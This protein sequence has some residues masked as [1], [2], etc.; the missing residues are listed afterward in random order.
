MLKR[1]KVCK[2]HRVGGGGGEGG[3]SFQAAADGAARAV[4]RVSVRGAHLPL[5]NTL[6]ETAECSWVRTVA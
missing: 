4:L 2:N 5:S 3:V 1:S 6:L